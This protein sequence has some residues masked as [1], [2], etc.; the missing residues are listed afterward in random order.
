ML[1]LLTFWK[2][3]Q[4][5]VV[6]PSSFWV[7]QGSLNLVSW[8]LSCG[9]HQRLVQR[10]SCKGWSVT[11]LTRT[12]GWAML[13]LI[14]LWNVYKQNKSSNSPGQ[15]QRT[16]SGQCGWAQS[17]LASW[18]SWTAPRTKTA[19]YNRRLLWIRWRTANGRSKRSHLPSEFIGDGNQQ[20]LRRKAPTRSWTRFRRRRVR[21]HSPWNKQKTKR[22]KVLNGNCSCLLSKKT[23]VL[24]EVFFLFE[25]PLE[26]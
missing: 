3:L 24:Q 19:V 16:T 15:C 6:F 13:Q 8:T 20:H 4:K 10:N 26:I 2:L 18:A 12:L 21:R 22:R 9:C 5:E 25:K 17:P 1:L 7:V 11:A 14:P 23:V